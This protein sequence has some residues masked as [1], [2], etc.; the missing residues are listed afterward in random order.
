MPEI[1]ILDDGTEKEVPTDEEISQWKQAK[2][3]L[4][5]TKQTV[6]K[7]KA[8]VGVKED[9]EVE[10]KLSELVE[11]PNNRNWH[12]ARETIKSL[13]KSLEERGVKVD[14]TGNIIKNEENLSID[15]IQEIVRKETD[16][17]FF[18]MKKESSLGKFNSEERKIVEP[19]FEK[20]MALG[21]SIEENVALAEL[22]IFPERAGNHAK[23]AFGGFR[24]GAPRTRERDENVS[25]EAKA[26]GS[27]IF[28]LSEKEL[29]E[30]G[31]LSLEEL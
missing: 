20:L 8:K 1:I 3:E 5:K 12:T 11:D 24:G 4:E 26:I 23:Q 13:K 21:G 14:D 18:E 10:E 28:G 22:K 15:K 29:K 16:T 19:V 31:K 2:D 27:S 30:G 6:E 17:K 9:A 25:D 7:I